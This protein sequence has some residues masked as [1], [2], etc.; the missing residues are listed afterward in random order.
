MSSAP[1]KYTSI[2]EIPIVVQEAREN[3]SCMRSL[4]FRRAQLFALL[5]MM[6]E[7]E[8]ELCDALN[9]DLHRCKAE[10]M[11]LEVIPVRKDICQAI[12]NLEQWVII[13]SNNSRMNLSLCQV[14][15]FLQWTV[16]KYDA[17]HL[18]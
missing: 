4:S 2:A 7:N 9:A 12:K 5:K 3:V 11:L 13:D 16:V 18:V 14:V 6:E 17:S 15:R 8:D 10:N 1:P